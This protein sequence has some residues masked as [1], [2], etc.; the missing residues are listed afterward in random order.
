MTSSYWRKD[1]GTRRSP[2]GRRC[3][4]RAAVLSAFGALLLCVPSASLQ[5][6]LCGDDVEGRDIPCDC[7]DTVVSSVVLSDDP[8]AERECPS[9]GLIVRGAQPGGGLTV[10][11]DGKKLRGS[12]TGAGIWI[13]SGGESGA[14]LLGGSGGATISG[15]RDGILASGVEPVAMIRDVIVRNCTRDGLRVGGTRYR[16]EDVESYSSGRDG[17]SLGGSD[18]TVVSS[19][20]VSSGRFGYLITGRNGTV[21]RNEEALNRATLSGTTGF[22]L[23]GSGHRLVGC[24]AL[25]NG[26]DGVALRGAQHHII[27]CRAEHNL[28]SGI[29]GTGSAWLLRA[30]STRANRNDGLVVRGAALVDGGGN[31]GSENLGEL[32]QRAAVQCE[33]GGAP[34]QR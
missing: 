19:Q 4:V 24:E 11:L 2:R 16:I 32:S 5:A 7:G 18:F 30:N 33:I 3:V 29:T 12:G 25:H 9:D 13:I 20:A 31:R 22:S 10:D 23:L 1:S 14:R 8:V 21:G 26:R 6:K 28:G 34:C 17:F 15:F 27:S